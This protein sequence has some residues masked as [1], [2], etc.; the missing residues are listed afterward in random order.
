IIVM[1]ENYR[2]GL[3]WNLFMSAPEVQQAM[4]K[5]NFVNS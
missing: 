2:T 3:C 5:L 4:A 1:I